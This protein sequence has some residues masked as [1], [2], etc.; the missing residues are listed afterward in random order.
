M[1][2]PR[3]TEEREKHD[4]VC[5]KLNGHLCHKNQLKAM[6]TKSIKY[7]AA[8]SYHFLE[9]LERSKA[10]KFENARSSH[11]VIHSSYS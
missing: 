3:E 9:N 8:I 5:Y 1:M 6:Q 2:L 7:Q 10:T 11:S 4:N